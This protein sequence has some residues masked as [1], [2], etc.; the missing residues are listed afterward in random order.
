VKITGGFV[1]SQYEN[2]LQAY[3]QILGPTVTDNY[4]HNIRF[5]HG[6]YGLCTDELVG[7]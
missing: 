6:T 3:Y 4:C 5:E 1:D 7:C 2:A